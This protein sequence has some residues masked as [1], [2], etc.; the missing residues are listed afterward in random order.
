MKKI[1]SFLILTFLFVFSSLSSQNVKNQ[2]VDV[3]KATK[4]SVVFI[5]VD[6]GVSQQGLT[7]RDII[8]YFYG[9]PMERD[10]TTTLAMGSGFIFKTTGKTTY[11]LTNYHIVRDAKN[12]DSYEITITLAD[13][14]QYDADI[15]GTN[16]Y[17]DMA[18]LKIKTDKELKQIKD[19]ELGDSEKIQIGEWVIAIGNPFGE[20][21]L[22]RTA[23]VG[24]VSALERSGLDFGENSPRYQD[25]IQTDAAI[26]PGN[27][28]GPL[29]NMDG[30]V[31]G[32]NSAISS[33][34]GAN[35]GI[36]FAIPINLVKKSVDDLLKYGRIRRARIGIY[37]S[38]ISHQIK[39]DMDLPSMNGVLIAK[40][41]DG[42]PAS[43]SGLRERDVI[44]RVNGKSVKN[45]PK[46]SI[47]VANANVDED[48][49]V[50]ILRNGR[51]KDVVVKLEE[52]E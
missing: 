4:N 39:Q 34:S 21:G 10:Y 18:I 47:F 9:L 22:E 27:S 20:V 30:Q 32:I 15:V 25:Y 1:V 46:F 48:F 16:P 52:I 43:K 11:I 41:V 5:K 7:Q 51:E 2:F 12:Y 36:G 49:V 13:R 29:I 35:A 42:S 40:V 38:D 6:V 44:L 23:T 24:V 17:I 45:F 37:A 33:P 28:G 14:E 3:I 19:L 31:I 50:G 8:R 26:N